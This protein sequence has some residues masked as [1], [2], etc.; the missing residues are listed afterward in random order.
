MAPNTKAASTPEKHGYEFGGPLGA[1]GVSFGLPILL[2]VFTFACNDVSGCPAPSLLSPKTLNLDT[3]KQEVG[4]PEGGISGLFSWRVTGWSLAYYLFSAVLYRVLPGA[5]VEGTQLSGGGRLK[6]KFNTL[7]SSIFT[8]V[9]CAA[10]TVAQGADFPVWTFISDNYLQL[11]TANILISYA[12]ATFVYVRSFSVKPGNAQFR[13]LAAGGHSGNLM[14]DW[15]IGRELNPRVALP[16]I[17]EIDIKEFMEVRPGLLGW[18]L[19]NCAFVA[20]Q[21]RTF[22]FVTDSIVFITVVQAAYCIDSWIMEPAI[23]TTMDITTDGFGCMLAF[24]DL[25][26]VPFLYSLQTKY[27]STYPNSLGWLGLSVVA[28]ILVTGFSIFRLANMQK[29]TFRTNPNDPSVAHLTYIETRTGSK[30]ITSGWWGIARHINYF[31][32]WLQSWP[33]SLPTGM[34]GYVILSAGADAEGSCKMQDGR[35]VVQGPAKG[36][37]MVF[38]YFYIVYFAILLIHR[39]GRDD[40]KCSRK[41]GEDWEKYKRQVKYRIVPGIY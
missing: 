14:Y 26:W 33:Y 10:G 3:L 19:M 22:G 5:E 17:G 29:N 23:L 24:G 20:K 28:A 8:L 30:L 18:I 25:V 16:L 13:E 40:E 36:W 15:F 31:G 41:Y 11:L 2:Y 21:Y 6:Y 39:D 4:W 7:A 35:E 32:D 38:T 12:L 9:L 34:A 27:L 1:A 37:G